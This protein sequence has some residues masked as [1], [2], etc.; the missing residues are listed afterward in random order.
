[1]NKNLWAERSRLKTVTRDFFSRNDYIEI[2]TPIAVVCPGTEVHL[3]Y[4]ETQW[5]D[6]LGKSHKMHLRSSPELHMKQALAQGF[7]KI[8]QIAPCFRNGG[9]RSE[10][11]QPEFTM[12]EWYEISM[13][14]QGLMQ[15]TELFLRHSAAEMLKITGVIPST[16]IPDKFEQWSVY[17]AF[18]EFAGI[19]LQDQ[20]PGLAGQCIE[21]GLISVR[22]QDDFETAYFKTLIERVEPEIAKRRGVVLLDYPPSQAAL[23]LVENGRACRFEFYVGRVELCNGFFELTGGDL[24]RQ[25][26]EEA[27][28]QRTKSGLD[29]IPDDP[30]F[31]NA[32]DQL[33]SPFAGNA[34]GFDRWLA[35]LCGQTNLDGAIPFRNAKIWGDY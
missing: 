27:M 8:F 21:N 5:Q 18:K 30:D 25:R 32:M 17:D 3:Q 26:V 2:D 19:T 34:L 16:I 9:E 6:A 20:D 11:H 4:F 13:T 24:N 10:W 23:A 28:H 29:R 33:T 7:P 22:P 12:L 15:Q 14:Y 1:M 35:L 31:F